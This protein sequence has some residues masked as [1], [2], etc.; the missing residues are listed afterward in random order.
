MQKGHTFRVE[1]FVLFKKVISENIL[2]KDKLIS[3]WLKVLS[4][5]YLAIGVLKGD[6][7]EC[8]LQQQNSDVSVQ[9]HEFIAQNHYYEDVCNKYI[10]NFV[11]VEDQNAARNSLSID[12]IQEELKH[13]DSIHLVIRRYSPD[14]ILKFTRIAISNIPGSEGDYLFTFKDIDSEIHQDLEQKE[15]LRK[16]Y[17]EVEVASNAKNEFMHN[18]SHDIRTPLNAIIGYTTIASDHVDDPESM[19][20]YLSKIYASSQNLLHIVNEILDLGELDSNNIILNETTLT[21]R[22]LINQV[23][24]SVTPLVNDKKLNFHVYM[25]GDDNRPLIMDSVHLERVFVNLIQNSIKFTENGGSIDF[26]IKSFLGQ[27]PSKLHYTF[28]IEDTGIGISENFIDKVFNPY[29]RERTSTQSRK[30]G[31]GVGLTIVKNIIDALHG[32]ITVESKVNVGTKFTI[33]LDFETSGEGKVSSSAQTT[34]PATNTIKG[35]RILVVDDSK[36]NRDI[37]TAILEGLSAKVEVASDGD[38]AV[39]MYEASKPGYYD[40]ILM[41]IQMPQMDGHEATRNI[42]RINRTDAKLIPIIALTADVFDST[43]RDS[44]ACGM[45]DF[46]T[47]PINVKNLTETLVKYF[48]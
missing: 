41:D 36:V 18:M 6:T 12:N 19:R 44:L 43:K 3:N 16:A 23:S 37:A 25:D 29:E 32:T 9:M 20:E 7:G 33:D 2:A 22:A 21:M 27:N 28:T 40:M 45:N 34:V 14:R 13:T 26:H 42:R 10:E 17:R 46:L 4:K 48:K 47:K 30:E 11:Y 38:V 39:S 8:I 31:V 35:K 24:S 5:E 1:V 15:Q